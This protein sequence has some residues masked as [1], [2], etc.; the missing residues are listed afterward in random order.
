[1]P[2][3]DLP[4]GIGYA[5]E[6]EQ[7]MYRPP[8]APEPF[9]AP[10][11]TASAVNVD[12][13]ALE[14]ADATFKHAKSAFDKFLNSIPLEHY[15]TEGLRQQVKKFAD[16]EAAKAVDTAEAAV[17]ARADQAADTY[18]KIREDLSPNGDTAAELRATRYWERTRALLDS[19][20]EGAFGKAQKLLAAADREQLGVLLQELP[21]YL[22]ARGQTT[23]WIDN[24][25]AQVV[26]EY[27]T[28]AKRH[29]RAQQ[30]LLITKSNAKKL[31]EAFAKGDMGTVIILTDS[32]GY[33][34]EKT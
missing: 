34:P 31:R 14:R 22:E 32:R 13:T 23:S 25:V 18:A 29:Q 9:V 1:M 2:E 12:G 20:K 33:D 8:L 19:A 16:T 24:A 11:V 28:A 3:W 21:D 26:P 27:A 30:A 5:P 10:R 4:N 15:S 17:Q 7:R 6:P